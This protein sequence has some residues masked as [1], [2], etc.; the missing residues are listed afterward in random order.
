VVDAILGTGSRGAARGAA[1]EAILWAARASAARIAVD[2]PSGVDPDTG[3]ASGPAF[4]ADLTITFGRSKPGLHIT[5]GRDLA[6]RIV[7]APIGL[8]AAPDHEARIALIDPAWVSAAV[9][10]L[11]PAAH[12]GRRG[13]LAVLGG[14]AGTPGAAVLAGAGALRA[15][16]GLVTVVAADPAVRAQLVAYR[17]ELM[18]MERSFA[19]APPA[20]AAQ[21]LVVGPGLTTPDER[22]G[23]EALYMSDPRPCLWDASALDHVPLG[24]ASPAGPRIITPH[25]GEAA[26]IL[27][28]A[29]GEP[30][31][32]T[33]V[34]SDRLAAVALLSQV[35]R[36]TAVLKGAG[37]LVAEGQRVAICTSGGEELA[38]AGTGDCLAG[39]IGGLLARMALT[40]TAELAFVAACVGVHV[41]GRAGELAAQTRPGP[42]A[43]DVADHAAIAMLDDGLP[44]R[45]PRLR[46]G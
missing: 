4:S 36:A 46:L 12:K 33:R 13:H 21:A 29:T 32:A 25:A 10:A 30:W 2:L 26:R 42:L 7:V 37:T 38:S 35:T 44:T 23:L 27:A 6:G 16:A 43:M 9:R 1:A 8:S 19:G 5:P 3:A 41:H 31:D 22:E 28:R 45:W 24:G 39:I 40:S 11:P 14:S 34:Q 18:V 15:G 20:G 17:P